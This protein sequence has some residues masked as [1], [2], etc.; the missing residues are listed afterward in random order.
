MNPAPWRIEWSD[1]LSMH[2]PE[3]DAE[4]KEFVSLVNKLNSAIIGRHNK[5]D[6]ESILNQIVTH[7][8]THF[9]HE[10]K[11]FVEMHYPNTQEHMQHH[12]GLIMTLNKTLIDIHNTEFSREWID[13]GLAIKH[14]LVDHLLIDD[15]QYIEQLRTE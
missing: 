9:S 13:M 3:I 5:A 11:L 8:I 15:A 4:H 10:E 12:S 7:S 6:I 14:A 1:D 2:N